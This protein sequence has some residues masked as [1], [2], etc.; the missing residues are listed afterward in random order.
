MSPAPELSA[1][2]G[3]GR[4]GAD[5][6]AGVGTGAGANVNGG[7]GDE[8]VKHRGAN[9]EIGLG[10]GPVRDASEQDA[11]GPVAVE[12][13]ERAPVQLGDQRR[14]VVLVCWRQVRRELLLSR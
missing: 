6:G 11:C 5:A 9:A 14:F 8:P 4:G 2:G 1:G 7:R 3:R 12:L 10:R 13:R